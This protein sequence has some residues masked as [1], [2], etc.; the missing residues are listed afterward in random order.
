MSAPKKIPSP[1]I[2]L[3]TPKNLP[4]K[5]R[6]IVLKRIT[7]LAV[8]KIENADT[9]R[10][11]DTA[12]TIKESNPLAIGISADAVIIPRIRGKYAICAAFSSEIFAINFGTTK[13][14]ASKVI[15]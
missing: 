5:P 8:L 12:A 6:G 3:F 9:I 10:L 1:T 13:N 2:K 11:D 14:I 4:S 15:V 7:E